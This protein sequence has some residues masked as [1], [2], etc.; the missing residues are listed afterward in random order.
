MQKMRLKLPRVHCLMVTR[1]AVQLKFFDTMDA[2]DRV[3]I[4]GLES[5]TG[6]KLNGCL[7][8]IIKKVKGKDGKM[9]FQVKVRGRDKTFALRKENL[10]IGT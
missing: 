9:R 4:K 5:E 7:G 6:K 1:A 8:F 10:A 2:G 3:R